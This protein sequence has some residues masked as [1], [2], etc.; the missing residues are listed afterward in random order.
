MN[1][2]ILLGVLLLSSVLCMYEGEDNPV[3]SLT[4]DT[5]K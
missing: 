3:V 4:T 2:K 5:H 1:N